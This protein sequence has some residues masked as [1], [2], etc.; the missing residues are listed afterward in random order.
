MGAFDPLLKAV[1]SCRLGQDVLVVV[2]PHVTVT[3]MAGMPAPAL[4]QLCIII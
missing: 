1:S 4:I 2:P 3:V